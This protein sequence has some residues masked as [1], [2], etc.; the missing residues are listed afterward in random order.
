MIRPVKESIVF[1]KLFV[2]KGHRAAVLL[3]VV[4]FWLQ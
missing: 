4:N 1:L 3:K 2:Y